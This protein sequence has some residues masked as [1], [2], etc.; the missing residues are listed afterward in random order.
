MP[1]NYCTRGTWENWGNI[2][3]PPALLSS[4]GDRRV[5]KWRCTFLQFSSWLGLLEWTWPSNLWEGEKNPKDKSSPNYYSPFNSYC[6]QHI[7]HSSLCS[8]KRELNK[9]YFLSQLVVQFNDNDGDKLWIRRKRESQKVKDETSCA[10]A[11][12]LDWLFP[13]LK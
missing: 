11:T 9:K 2:S 12:V 6:L 7:E 8:H 3:P 5:A 4:W 13:D 1:H 10:L